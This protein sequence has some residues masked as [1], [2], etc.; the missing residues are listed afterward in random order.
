MEREIEKQKTH[1]HRLQAY[2]RKIIFHLEDDDDSHN[3][4]N[5]W[6]ENCIYFFLLLLHL[7]KQVLEFREK[8]KTRLPMVMANTECE[9]QP[10]YWIDWRRNKIES[11]KIECIRIQEQQPRAHYLSVSYVSSKYSKTVEKMNNMI[12]NDV[13]KWK[14]YQSRYIHNEAYS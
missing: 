14:W 9:R 5:Q 8:K 4:S 1:S 3:T 2:F 10:P 7:T 12:I 13:E 6:R 11:M